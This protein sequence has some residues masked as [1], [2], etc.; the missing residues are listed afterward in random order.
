M[1]GHIPFNCHTLRAVL[2]L[3]PDS[4]N[5]FLFSVL[6]AGYVPDPGWCQAGLQA[7]TSVPLPRV[8]PH[9]QER[10]RGRSYSVKDKLMVHTT[11]R[12]REHFTTTWLTFMK[13]KDD[14]FVY[15]LA[16]MLIAK[17]AIII[18]V[19]RFQDLSTCCFLIV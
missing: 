13:L 9:C 15:I 10:E 4:Q 12:N 18:G 8:S 16:A 7:E 3:Q 11:Y 2:S 5:C 1:N 17:F 19:L 6:P 14:S